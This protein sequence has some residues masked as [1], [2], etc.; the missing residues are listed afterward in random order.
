MC[1]AIGFKANG[2]YF[3]RNLDLYYHF[4]E[5]VTVTPREFVFNF[6]CEKSVVSHLA[7]IGIAT[8]SDGYPL[9]YDAV[10]EAGL[11]MAGLNF[12]KEA[13]YLPYNNAKTNIAP[14]ELI[15][16]ILSRCK[17]VDDAQKELENINLWDTSFS[18]KYEN[19]PLHWFLCD[20]YRALTIEPRC[21]GLKIYDNHVGVLTNSPPFDY[22]LY[23]LAN[24]INV[25]SQ[26]PKN[27]FCKSPEITPYSLG[28]GSF[29]LPGDMSSASRFVRAA[30]IKQNSV[31]AEGL[32]QAFHILKAVEQPK[33]VTFTADGECEY[34]LYT[35]VCDVSG[36]VYYYKTYDSLGV[37]A[38]SLKNENL[39]TKRLI[40]Y[41]LRCEPIIKYC[42]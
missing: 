14:F 7:I 12:P 41:P 3:G 20:K 34:T 21:D 11:C 19:T 36:G 30:F 13:A 32:S 35:S 29:G 22:H 37:Y 24:Y 23:N 10:N 40:S 28:M 25:T 15:P 27:R 38:V 6:R 39:D 17:S 4:D 33:G 2:F 8:L 1:T 16:Y 31:S 26:Y 42:N 18:E 5:S 9:Y